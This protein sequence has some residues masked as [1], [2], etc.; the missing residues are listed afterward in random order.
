VTAYSGKEKKKKKS[1]RTTKTG[2][3]GTPGEKKGLPGEK[4]YGHSEKDLQ[5]RLGGEEKGNAVLTLHGGGKRRLGWGNKRK[6]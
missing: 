2:K 3:S 4:K 6:M 5:P 1:E